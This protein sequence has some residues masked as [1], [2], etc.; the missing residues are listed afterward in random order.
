MQNYLV[1]FS[2]TH[3]VFYYW[4]FLYIAFAAFWL[5]LN[6]NPQFLTQ[7]SIL[8]YFS[9]ISVTVRNK[10]SWLLPNSNVRPPRPLL[11]GRI[12]NGRFRMVTKKTPRQRRCL[13]FKIPECVSIIS[14]YRIFT[15]YPSLLS[16]STIFWRKSP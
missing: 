15:M 2:P 14:I 13:L 7:S 5:I 16:W 6:S 10:P 12:R 3:L 4:N 8:N 11:F 9:R 1:V